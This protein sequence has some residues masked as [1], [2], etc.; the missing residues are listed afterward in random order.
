MSL[1]SNSIVFFAAAAALSAGFWMA[2][3]L[4][5]SIDKD[6]EIVNKLA[7]DEAR[8]GYSPIQGNILS[9]PRK[10]SVPAL[11]KDNA[12]KFTI[13]D[14]KDQWHIMF[15]GY[16]HCP[17][18]CPT[19]MGT[20]AQAKKIA[21]ANKDVF[22][23]VIFVSVD[24]ERDKVELLS[25]YL[26]YFDKDFIGVTGDDDLIRALTLQMSVVYLKMPVEDGADA[27]NYVVDHS[28]ALLLLN[29]EGRL[30]A[31]L[32]PPF[33]PEGILKDIRTVVNLSKK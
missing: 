32:N 19:T 17:D 33:T 27:D 4:Q 1:K 9:P 6:A 13:D 20:L 18:V 10:I 28:A 12:E 16:T 29:P 8:R 24:P 7:L 22:P 3:Q 15:F 14:L 23:Q 5:E 26:K 30:V 11:F 21:T 2:S 31:F 25:D